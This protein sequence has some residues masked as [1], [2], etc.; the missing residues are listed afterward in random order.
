MKLFRAL[1]EEDGSRSDGQT[2]RQTCVL[3][4]LTV[5]EEPNKGGKGGKGKTCS[6]V[7]GQ[8]KQG[9]NELLPMFLEIADFFF[10]FAEIGNRRKKT[11]KK[12]G[13]LWEDILE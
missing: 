10:F 9:K 5:C 6:T 7:I 11:K 4:N 12:P 3:G 8:R 2:D 13:E 1:C